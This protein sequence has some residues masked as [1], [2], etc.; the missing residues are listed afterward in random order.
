M[1]WSLP[2]LAVFDIEE[3]QS[4]NPAVRRYAARGR[5]FDNSISLVFATD[6]IVNGPV[7]PAFDVVVN[8]RRD[9]VE[10]SL[11]V[12]PTTRGAFHLIAYNPT[13]LREGGNDVF[14]LENALDFGAAAHLRAV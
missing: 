10:F 12:Q 11:L 8:D 14:V 2:E 7:L 5:N 13:D 4:S 9:V 6:S 1:T 3:T